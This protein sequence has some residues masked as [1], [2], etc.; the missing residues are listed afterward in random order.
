MLYQEIISEIPFTPNKF[1]K[2]ENYRL[3]HQQLQILFC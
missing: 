2:T 1:T 3:I